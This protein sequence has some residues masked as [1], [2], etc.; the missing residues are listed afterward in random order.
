[1]KTGFKRIMKQLPKDKWLRELDG[2]LETYGPRRIELLRENKLHMNQ[3]EF[4]KL[5]G[6]SQAA[7]SAWERGEYA[8]SAEVYSRL[9]NLEDGTS[10]LQYW[11]LAGIDPERIVSAVGLLLKICGAPPTRRQISRLPQLRSTTEV[12]VSTAAR[13][14]SI[15]A[16]DV[17]SLVESGKIRARRI[18][19]VGIC[20]VEYDSLIDYL[21]FLRKKNATEADA[22]RSLLSKKRGKRQ[23]HK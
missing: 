6:V 5:L 16:G 14:L 7:V 2:A 22:G 13:I 10:A 15:E 18:D 11:A 20:L 17:L 3:Q 21:Q 9:G 8:P 19:P 12:P 1:M 23:R 4:A